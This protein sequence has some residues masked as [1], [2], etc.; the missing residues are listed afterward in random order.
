MH[1]REG[2]DTKNWRRDWKSS[3]HH[4]RP[5]SPNVR[6]SSPLHLFPSWSGASPLASLE[7][8]ESHRQEGSHSVASNERPHPL[9][10]ISVPELYKIFPLIS[11]SS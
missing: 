8:R 2:S 11:Q 3:P 9:L 7:G 5:A 1:G 6:V 4:C 10:V